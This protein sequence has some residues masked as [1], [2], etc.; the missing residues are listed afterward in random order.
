MHE[1]LT[2][3]IKRFKINSV[4]ILSLIQ[5]GKTIR[6][7]LMTLERELNIILLTENEIYF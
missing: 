3:P 2:N 1:C 6:K 5:S 4:Q 7:L